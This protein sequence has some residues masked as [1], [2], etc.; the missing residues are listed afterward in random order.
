MGLK[1]ELA[2]NA[3][4]IGA[5]EINGIVTTLGDPG[6]DANVATEKAVRDAIDLI[7]PAR[8]QTWP[9]AAR[10]S[11]STIT[12]TTHLVYGTPIRYRATAGTWRYGIVSSLSTHTHTISGHPCT[13]SDD[14]EF[15]F[16][17]PCLVK[18]I[19][20]ILPGNCIVADPYSAIFYWQ[21]ATAYCVRSTWFP[22]VAPT[23]ATLLGNIE[24]NGADLHAAEIIMSS[25]AEVGSAV[26]IVVGAYD[27]NFSETFTVT[28]SQ[29]GSTIPGGNPLSVTLTWVFP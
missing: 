27:I 12:S 18:Q 15:Q 20:L 3:L 17:Q 29:I 1:V 16:G 8:W 11:D 14:D 26:D 24:I 19:N 22:T 10:A 5:N 21:M 6:T 23:G 2:C 28:I 7:G 25:A 9:G 4:N 13:T